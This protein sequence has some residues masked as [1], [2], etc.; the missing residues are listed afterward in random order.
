MNNRVLVTFLLTFFIVAIFL[1]IAFLPKLFN[2]PIENVNNSVVN[3]NIEKQVT[4]FEI[5]VAYFLNN[6]SLSTRMQLANAE[7]IAFKVA[8]SLVSSSLNIGSIS[9]VGLNAFFNAFSNSSQ[10]TLYPSSTEYDFFIDFIDSFISDI[11]IHLF[12]MHI[13]NKYAR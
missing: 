13:T 2:K 5:S 1:G 4:D 6:I 11:L 3:E 10:N 9:S 7:T 8:Y 12:K